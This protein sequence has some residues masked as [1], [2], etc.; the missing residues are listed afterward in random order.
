MRFV[1]E[2]QVS[3]CRLAFAGLGRFRQDAED[4]GVGVVSAGFV[5][6]VV[7]WQLEAAQFFGLVVLQPGDAALEGVS[8]DVNAGGFGEQEAM[9]HLCGRMRPGAFAP[10]AEPS[11]A[12]VGALHGAQVA[13]A[14]GNYLVHFVFV[15]DRVTV[16]A[17]PLLAAGVRVAQLLGVEVSPLLLEVRQVQAQPAQGVAGQDGWQ[18][19]V[20]GLF[21]AVVGVV[22][23][24]GNGVQ[25]GHGQA[26]RPAHGQASRLRS[27][28]RRDDQLYLGDGLVWPQEAGCGDGFVNA[29]HFD[30][31]A[32]LHGV[33]FSLCQ[34][35]HPDDGF[36]FLDGLGAP[37]NA[38]FGAS[39]NDDGLSRWRHHLQAGAVKFQF[40]LDGLGR[41]QVVVDIGGENHLVF[42]HQEAR[43][44]QAEDQVF[45]GDQ[46]SCAHA[47]AGMVVH[48]PD[49]HFPS[50]QVFR[51]RHC[52]LGGAV[53]LG[54]KTGDPERCVSELAADS[55]WGG[56][57]SALVG[58]ESAFH[59]DVAGWRRQGHWLGIRYHQFAN[60]A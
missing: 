53:R 46:L 33:R 51:H 50:S 39:S 15:K 19:S 25:H 55:D 6:A 27:T 7:F 26:G 57:C 24:V 40:D 12:A 3:H 9:H 32:L 37:V 34:S 21:S 45:A 48:P 13:H 43:R 18:E 31:K 5:V 10:A 49:A 17:L 42:L 54:V 8:G 14:G 23:Q 52:H 20:Q 58:A 35:E 59:G 56:G 22:K 1:A 47:D 30:W 38:G 60:C 16:T 36:A 28:F 2:E 11:P 44:L 4:E 41:R 29:M